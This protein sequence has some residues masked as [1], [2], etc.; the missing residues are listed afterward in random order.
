MLFPRKYEE[1]GSLF[2]L[3]FI[4]P[5]WLQV[6]HQE[7]LQ[8]PKISSMIHQLQHNSPASPGYS[9]HNEELH[10]YNEALEAFFTI[11]ENAKSHIHPKT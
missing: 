1:E 4:V 6:V 10:D 7:W 8:D 5:D 9:W 11:E 2:S 3:S